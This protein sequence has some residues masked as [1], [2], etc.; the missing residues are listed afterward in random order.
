ME[1]LQVGDVCQTVAGLRS[2]GSMPDCKC[3]HMCVDGHQVGA[4]CTHLRLVLSV[5]RSLSRFSL[6]GLHPLAGLIGG[7]CGACL[8]G[9]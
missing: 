7:L 9:G 3:A 5:P 2:Q 6:R 4:C 8:H 1:L